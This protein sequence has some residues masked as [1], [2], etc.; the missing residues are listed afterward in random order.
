MR[1]HDKLMKSLSWKEQELRE[2]KQRSVQ[3]ED[4]AKET[5]SLQ[6]NVQLLRAQYE[7]EKRLVEEKVRQLTE[8]QT[9]NPNEKALLKENQELKQLNLELNRAIKEER[10]VASEVKTKM[11]SEV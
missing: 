2:F 10:L 11:A 9:L 8:L 4:S 1:E 7:R 6:R 3:L 5:E